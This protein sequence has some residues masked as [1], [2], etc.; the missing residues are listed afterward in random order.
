[1]SERTL[2]LGPPE[3]PHDDCFILA[4]RAGLAALRDAIDAILNNREPE[5]VSGF[6]AF[7]PDGEGADAWVCE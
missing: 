4:D 7:Q 1:M 6:V 2:V 5:G 3:F